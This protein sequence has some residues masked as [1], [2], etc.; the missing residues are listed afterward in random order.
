MLIENSCKRLIYTVDPISGTP[1]HTLDAVDPNGVSHSLPAVIDDVLIGSCHCDIDENVLN[2]SGIWLFSPVFTYSEH[3]WY[4]T[5][6]FRKRV[7]PV[8]DPPEYSEP[9]F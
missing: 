8:G 1:V 2:M 7:H 3:V 4:T 6:A 5:Y 9:D